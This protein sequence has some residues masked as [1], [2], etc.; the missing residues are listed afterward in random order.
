MKFRAFAILT[1]AAVTAPAFAQ[2]PEPPKPGW[3]GTGE[4]GYVST[5]GNTDSEALNMRLEFIKTTVDWRHRFLATALTTSK[6]GVEDA[7]RYTLEAQSDRKL[8]ARS[9]LFG[10]FRWDADKFGT[11]DPQSSLT[12]GYGRELWASA[13][14]T[15][16]GEAGI[17]Y[18]K[19]EERVS[20]ETSSDAILR[21]VGDH[22][23]QV[24]D[25]TAWTNRLLVESGSDNTFS[26]FNTALAVAMNSKFAVKLGYEIRH[27][28]DV[29]PGNSDKTDTITTINLVYNFR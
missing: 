7:E 18:R 3:A 25:N 17:G 21:L 12:F 4:F 5:S 27:N 11:Y 1:L 24:T 28:S 20:G 26:Q 10:A 22:A 6:N 23:W 19:L 15:I 29:P 2:D 14:Q 13:T 8:N 9:W 16:K